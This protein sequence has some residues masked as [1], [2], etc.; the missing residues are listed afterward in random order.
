LIHYLAVFEIHVEINGVVE[1]V[2]IL[3]GLAEVRVIS[4]EPWGDGA[5][6]ILSDGRQGRIDGKAYLLVKA[7]REEIITYAKLMVFVTA[8]RSN[9]AKEFWEEIKKLP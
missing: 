4:A 2:D 9:E 7:W 5:T 8:S 3:F 1:E 6:A